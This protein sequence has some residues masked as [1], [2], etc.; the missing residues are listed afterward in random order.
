MHEGEK[1]S[2]QIITIN[3]F[4]QQTFQCLLVFLALGQGNKEENDV[5][6]LSP[7]P[8]QVVGGDT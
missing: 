3:L 2:A 1:N 6:V 4:L 7:T 8:F 5:V